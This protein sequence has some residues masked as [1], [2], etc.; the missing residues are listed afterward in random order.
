MNKLQLMLTQAWRT[1]NRLLGLLSPLAWL[2]GVIGYIHKTLYDSGICKRYQSPIPVWVVGNITVGGSGKT[3]LI[4]ELVNHLQGLGISVGVISRG[5]GKEGKH[6]MMVKPDSLPNQVGDE[7]CLIV[8]NT[9]VPMAVGA[10]RQAAIEL[11]LHHHPKLQLILS[12]DGLQHYAL[13]RDIEWIVVDG[14]RGFGNEK[15]LPQGF[16]RQSIE[17]LQ[18]A[19]VIYHDP[20]QWLYRSNALLMHLVA[21]NPIPLLGGGRCLAVQKVYAVSG[22]GYPTRFFDTLQG[23]GFEVVQKPFADHHRFVLSDLAGLSDLP[24]VVTSKD[25]IKLK[26]LAQT[27][28]EV[29]ERIWILPVYAKLSDG[30]YHHIDDLVQHLQ[31]LDTCL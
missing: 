4:I 11:L 2:Y 28:H 19:T 30:V 21:T 23:L 10:N 16:L 13:H 31:L 25:A 22:I 1:Q 7:P 18:G 12:D 9:Q 24:I 5:Y 26:H 15:L 14:V 29:F 3:P 8:Q 27:P 17:R 6:A 20:R